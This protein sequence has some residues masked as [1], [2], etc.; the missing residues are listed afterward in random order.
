M[1]SK[2]AKELS[3]KDLAVLLIALVVGIGLLSGCT[4][5]GTALGRQMVVA[6]ALGAADQA[7]RNV[8]SD[9]NPSGGSG[10]GQHQQTQ[11]RNAT[12]EKMNDGSIYSG[13]LLRCPD[14]IWRCHGYGRI[15]YAN[16]NTYVGEFA[17]GFAEGRGV[18]DYADG[19]RYEGGMRRNTPDGFGTLIGTDGQ[20]YVGGH[21]DGKW[22]GKGRWTLSNGAVIEG[23]WENGELERGTLTYVNGAVYVGE[24]KNRKR[25]GTGKYTEKDGK[26]LEGKWG[27]DIFRQGVIIRTDGTRIEAE[28]DKNGKLVGKSLITNIRGMR[29][30]EELR[31]GKLY[32]KGIEVW[33]DGTKFEGIWDYAGKSSGTITYPGGT[34]Y[35]GDWKIVS[36]EPDLPDGEG[37][38]TWSD[39][40]KYI[41]EFRDGKMHGL[42]KMTYADGKVEEG[43]WKQDQFTGQQTAVATGKPTS[44]SGKQ[45]TLTVANDASD[46][47]VLVDGAFMGN[48]PAKL[49][50]TEGAHCVEVK[51]AGCK[52]Y[53]KDVTVSEGSELTLRPVLEKE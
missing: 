22:N 10:G 32:R 49:R 43:V 50:L 4:A 53:K 51:K 45:G 46:C 18:I 31:N 1:T 9:N 29:I 25:H 36:G 2:K 7:G 11:T 37:A 15:R 33:P 48:T 42:G 40:R 27:D 19:R 47:E 52:T 39:G 6:A 35:K 34:Q 12:D 30:E 16:G 21:R 26:V 28:F 24:F 3:A 17:E 14:G 13:P 23:E 44:N 20:K 38:M 5:A 41:G 8:V